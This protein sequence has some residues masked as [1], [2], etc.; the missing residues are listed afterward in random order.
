MSDSL[1]KTHILSG[2]LPWQTRDD[3][4]IHTN[5]FVQQATI[6]RSFNRLL[7]NDIVLYNNLY[8]WATSAIEDINDEDIVCDVPLSADF[9][10]KNILTFKKNGNTYS[11]PIFTIE[12]QNA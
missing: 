4:N 11:I 12:K 5:E 6:N 8:V 10:Y 9:N 2:I 3:V 7:E 1:E